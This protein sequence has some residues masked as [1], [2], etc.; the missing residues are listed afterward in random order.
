M[1]TTPATPARTSTRSLCRG[2]RQRQLGDG[3]SARAI[4]AQLQR[5]VA[6][7]PIDHGR[8]LGPRTVCPG[9]FERLYER[10]LPSRIV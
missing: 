7:A 8:A 10:H 4:G 3:T 2:A 1:K 6:I 5:Q 9:N